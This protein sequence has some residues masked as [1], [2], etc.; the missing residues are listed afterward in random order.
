METETEDEYLLFGVEE[1]SCTSGTEES[2]SMSLSDKSHS[3]NSSDN[4]VEEFI[5]DQPFA[6]KSLL[7]LFI[8][9]VHFGKFCVLYL[10]IIEIYHCF[11]KT[12]IKN[13][14]IL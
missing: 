13:K 4:Q 1:S 14:A 9:R 12:V 8:S 2:S 11:Y 10:K 5:G 6:G 7:I 3:N